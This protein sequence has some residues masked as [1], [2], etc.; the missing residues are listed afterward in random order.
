MKLSL[1][2]V[3]LLALLTAATAAGPAVANPPGGCARDYRLKPQYVPCMD[4][5]YKNKGNSFWSPR[6]EAWAR[7]LCSDKGKIVAKVDVKNAEDKT[8]H[9]TNSNKREDSGY[10][11]VR[12]IYYCLDISDDDTQPPVNIESV[13]GEPL[14]PE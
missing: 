3:V 13:G 2:V 1:K 12:G 6:W 10:G 4:G 14:I 5:G 8:W 11:R 7:N 9:I